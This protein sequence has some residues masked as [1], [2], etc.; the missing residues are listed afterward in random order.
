[1][2]HHDVYTLS[3]YAFIL[4]LLHFKKFGPVVLS[5]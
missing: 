4:C 3:N 5:D 1:M 2:T